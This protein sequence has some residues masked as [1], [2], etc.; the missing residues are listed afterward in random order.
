MYVVVPVDTPQLI[1]S[2]VTVI[3]LPGCVAVHVAL[4]V[5]SAVGATIAAIVA[6]TKDVLVSAAADTIVVPPMS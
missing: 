1:Q 6:P 3:V 4:N 2:N 5:A